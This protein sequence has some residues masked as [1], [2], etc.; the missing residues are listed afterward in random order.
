MD[1][2]HI[3]GAIRKADKD[4]ELINKD[5]RIALA[6]SGGKDSMLLFLALAQYQ[7]FEDKD[8]DLVGIHVDVGFENIEHELMKE[9]CD[10]HQLNL[11]IEKTQIFEIL[12][13][14]P[15]K[16]NGISCSLCSTLKKGVLFDKAKELGCNKV[17]YGHHGDDAVETLLLNMMYGSKIATFRPKQYMSRQDMD[18]IRPL[19]YVKEKEVIQSCKKNEIPSVKRVCPN[20]GYTQRQ[21]VKDKLHAFYKEYPFAQDAFLGSLS[22][23]EQVIL[24]HKKS[25]K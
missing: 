5:D 23:E 1:L 20:D 11:H 19:V 16:Q 6:L 2:K 4:F 7:K 3:L 25:L 10:K 24:W 17:A 18:L 22:N 15:T 8:F 14:H 9:F 12:K 13:M 21:A